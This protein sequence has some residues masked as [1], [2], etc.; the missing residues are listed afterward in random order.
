[1]IGPWEGRLLGLHCKGGKNLV[2]LMDQWKM[3]L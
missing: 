1:M 3:V 2:F